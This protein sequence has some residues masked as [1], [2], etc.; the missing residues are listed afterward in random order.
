MDNEEFRNPAQE[1]REI[2]FWSWNDLLDPDELRRQIRLMREGGWGGFFIHSR[3]GLR[4][5]YMG[6]DWLACVRAA[7]DEARSYGLQAWLYD[8]DKWPSGY[9]GGASVTG[10]PE[11]R[12]KRLV[13]KIDARPNLLAER[14]ATFRAREIDGVLQD[15][16]PDPAPR[17]AREDDRLIQFYPS[18]MALGNEIFNDYTYVDLL[19]AD[20]V[21]AFLNSTHAVYAGEI[22]AEFGRVVPGIFTDEPCFQFHRYI[23]GEFGYQADDLAVPWTGDLPEFFRAAN[24]YD[25]LPH[26]PC[27]FFDAGDYHKV[28]YDFYR[29]VTRMFVERFTKQVYRWCKQHG[30][31]FTGHF[32][33]E[34]TLLWQIPWVGAVMPHLALM[35]IP[36]IDKLGRSV[37]DFDAGMVL[38]LKQ[39]DSIACQTGKRRALCENY[40]CSGQNF[41][42]AGRKWIG[43][44]AY[45]LGVNLNN[46]HMALYSMAGERKRDCPPNLFFQQPWWPE[47]R[48]I[49]DYF[50]RLS[51]LLS[52]GDRRVD[53]LVI[54]PISSAWAAYRPGAAAPVIR[55]DQALNGLLLQLMQL[56]RDFHLGDEQLM[57]RGEPCEAHVTIDE[58]GPRFVVGRMAYRLIIVPPSITLSQ[59][60][61]RLLAEF[62]AAG[63]KVL[64]Q[65]PLP[66]LIDGREPVAPVLPDNAIVTSNGNL[67][68]ALDQHLPFDVRIA[69]HPQIWAHHREAGGQHIYFLANIDPDRHCQATVQVRC[70]GRVQA[71]DAATG[72]VCDLRA[73]THDDLTEIDL[74]FAPAG[75]HLFVIDSTQAPR[76]ETDRPQAVQAGKVLA[77]HWRIGLNEPNALILDTVQIQIEGMDWSSPMHVLDAQQVA[78]RAGTG[79]CYQLRYWFDTEEALTGAVCLVMET[80]QQFAIS[81]NGQELD[82]CPDRGWWIDPAFRQT[83]I[84][85]FVQIGRNEVHVMGKFNRSTEFESVYITGE[86]GVTSRLVRQENRL[87]GQIFDRYAPEYGLRS[88]P[89]S[90]SGDGAR[91][92]QIDLTSSGFPFFAGRMTLAQQ[93]ELPSIASDVHLEIDQLNAA[94]VHVRVNGRHA[95][96]AAW[97]PHRVKISDYTQVG[98]NMIEIELVGTLRNLLGPHHYAGGDPRRTN[99]E[100]FRDKVRWTDDYIL[101]PFGW[102]QVRLCW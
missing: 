83:E 41:S 16:C 85:R 73:R 32:M 69:G 61:S 88:L 23:Y 44:W 17:L 40:G 70:R 86:F 14:I 49:S 3:A 58:N 87:T 20:A 1:Y 6:P 54:H 39:L 102:D 47:N 25:L 33:G 100:D 9:A 95:G 53:I 15:I 38:T 78:A 96:T 71:W 26:V 89:H 4:T 50:A 12:A 64:V 24:G 59:N 7:V 66:T 82:T 22:G 68:D 45:V 52:M 2:P 94:L 90:V 34:D 51:Y 21:A 29:T 42:H 67:S 65:E 63:G 99:P 98:A 10:N 11:Y 79:S 76:Q 13:C 60:T 27:L 28:R 48:L 97:P 46:P 5:P 74:D 80:P 18:V 77:N 19:N 56:Q 101:T 92:P 37:N 8:E 35:N 93:V 36:G 75:S 57:E 91:F 81:V 72:A 31:Q 55:L 30:L 43:D 62:A 84:T